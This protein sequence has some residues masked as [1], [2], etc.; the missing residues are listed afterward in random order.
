MTTF[1]R[2]LPR[3]TWQMKRQESGGQ[4]TT[5]STTTERC[6]EP[7]LVTDADEAGRAPWALAD[8]WD[9]ETTGLYHWRDETYALAV[10]M[11]EQP[12]VFVGPAC[13]VARGYMRETIATPGR[14]VIAYNAKFELHFTDKYVL[15]VQANIIDPSVALF[16]I[17]ENRF[18]GSGHGLKH[19]VKSLFGYEM[20]DFK[21]MLGYVT[22]ETGEYKTRKCKTCTGKGWRGRDHTQCESCAGVGMEARPVTRRRLRHISEVPLAELAKYAA[23]DVYWTK[24]VWEWAKAKL[25][26]NETLERNFHDVQMPLLVA[27]YDAEHHGIRIDKEGVLKLRQSYYDELTGLDKELE[28]KLGMVIEDVGYEDN[29]GD[30]E[31]LSWGAD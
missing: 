3:A 25:A 14:D 4:R 26:R 31:S 5:G 23:D 8:T 2:T 12:Y 1:A 15:D 21:R 29:D 30:G 28:R 19:A 24:R 11:G 9:Y 13:E 17:D 6:P 27:L 10:L 20:V 18:S 22:E 16:L 7:I